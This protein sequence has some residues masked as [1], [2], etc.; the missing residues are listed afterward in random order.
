MRKRLIKSPNDASKDGSAEWLDLERLAQVE[1]TSEEASHPVEAA[2]LLDREPGWRA[3]E[4]GEQRIRIL[5]MSRKNSDASNFSSLYKRSAR[6][7]SRC[8]GRPKRDKRRRLRGSS[9][10]SV[11]AGQPANSRNT[12]WSLTG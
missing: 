12:A 8:V 1:V 4:P 9:I 5:L 6:R 10:T 2:L 7:N 11:R 3:A